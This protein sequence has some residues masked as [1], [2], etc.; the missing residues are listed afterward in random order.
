[1]VVDLYDNVLS[2]TSEE[3]NEEFIIKTI[4]MDPT[5]YFDNNEFKN[6]K[7]NSDVSE[8][9]LELLKKIDGSY[10]LREP[11]RY[12]L[13]LQ[14]DGGEIYSEYF[15]DISINENPQIIIIK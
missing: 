13:V 3:I 11:L 4:P 6:T 12:N 7:T 15:S 5:I 10:V 2:K 14:L 8:S 1:M 9:V